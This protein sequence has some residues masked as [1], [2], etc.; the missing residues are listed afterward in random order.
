MAMANHVL[1]VRQAIEVA[2]R[3]IASGESPFGAVIATLDGDIVHAAHNTVRSSCDS[4]AHAEINVIR[5]ACRNLGVIHLTG[6]VIATTCEPCA[7]CAAAVHWA[8]LD[9]IIYGAA[10]AD[11]K[12][13]GFNELSLACADLCAQGGRGTAIHGGV[14]REECKALFDVWLAGPNPTPY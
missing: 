10:V 6:H 8:R 1:L 13:A 5:G 9:A 2:R 11:A 12:R 4:T 14:L 3:G 7:M